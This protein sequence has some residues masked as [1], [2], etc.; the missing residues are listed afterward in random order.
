MIQKKE[1][2]AVSFENVLKIAEK[3]LI[4]VGYSC[5][6]MNFGVSLVC[7][8][9]LSDVQKSGKTTL[10]DQLSSKSYEMRVSKWKRSRKF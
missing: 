5:I 4:F 7:S 9:N 3:R 8:L 1:K 2:A 6:E 10:C